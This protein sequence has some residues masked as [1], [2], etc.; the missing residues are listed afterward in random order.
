MHTLNEERGMN[1][2]PPRL[3]DEAI[4][5]LLANIRAVEQPV[6]TLGELR[7]LLRQAMRANMRIAW[8]VRLDVN[9]VI[10]DLLTVVDAARGDGE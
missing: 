2:Q 3:S 4:T 8:D 9:D 6:A 1:A 7:H 10:V 5:E